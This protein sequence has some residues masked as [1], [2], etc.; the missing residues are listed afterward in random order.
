MICKASEGTTFRDPFFPE[1]VR[2]ARR[3]GMT[4]GAYHWLSKQDGSVD[5][6]STFVSYLPRWWWRSRGGGSTILKDTVYVNSDYRPAP[7]MGE[8]AGKSPEI[9]QFTSSHDAKANGIP[10]PDGIDMNRAPWAVEEF[11]RRV[12]ARGGK[13]DV[14]IVDDA[15][16]DYLDRQFKEILARVDRAVQRIGGRSNAVYNNTQE[17]FLGLVMAEDVLAEAK[18]AREAATQV[19]AEVAKIKSH[20]GLH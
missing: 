12:G 10:H 11:A 3:H 7:N 14:S 16:K 17:D 18:A 8:Y 1:F 2:E 15:T 19:A 6:R 9:L 5:P 13:E 4:V 20:L